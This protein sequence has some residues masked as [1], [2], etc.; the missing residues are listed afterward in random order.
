[1]IDSEKKLNAH[2]IVFH[3]INTYPQSDEQEAKIIVANDVTKDGHRISISELARVEPD[4]EWCIKAM[5]GAH[6][7]ADVE[8]ADDQMAVTDLLRY[9]G[10]A[11]DYIRYVTEVE[12]GFYFP[13]ELKGIVI[14][15][16]KDEKARFPTKIDLEKTDMLED[17]LER[18]KHTRGYLNI[19][20]R[21]EAEANEL[22][23]KSRQQREMHKGRSKENRS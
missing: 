14:C 9:A 3:A 13:E 15:T 16:K 17:F 1:M 7:G 5:R 2:Q 12:A 8:C 6:R 4:V 11:I 19:M 22:Y 21:I 20:N 10:L 18:N 23:A